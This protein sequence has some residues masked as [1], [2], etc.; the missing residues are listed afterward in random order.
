[1]KLN[2]KEKKELIGALKKQYETAK[3]IVEEE[4]VYWLPDEKSRNRFIEENERLRER[5]EAL[6]QQEEVDIPL[7]DSDGKSPFSEILGLLEV[8][9]LFCAT[10]DS[11]E[12]KHVPYIEPKNNIVN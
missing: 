8:I 11:V 7:F 1:M 2:E 5:Y 9:L 6:E 3:E 4:N 12:E 10:R